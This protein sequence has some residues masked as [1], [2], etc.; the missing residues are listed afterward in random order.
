MSH[1]KELDEAYWA[2]VDARFAEMKRKSLLMINPTAQISA[3]PLV[4]ELTRKM[5]AA[6]RNCRTNPDGYLGFHT[7]ACGAESDNKDHWIRYQGGEGLTNS[8]CI[9]YLAFHRDEISEEELQKVALLEDGEAE[10][11]EVELQ[12]RWALYTRK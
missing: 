12:P 1:K 11:T 2:E 3:Q 8:L 4:D 6:W 5:T 10:P 7:C 9:H